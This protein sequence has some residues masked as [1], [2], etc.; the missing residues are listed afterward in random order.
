MLRPQAHVMSLRGVHLVDR[1]SGDGH[2]IRVVDVVTDNWGW[3]NDGFM[4]R[5]FTFSFEAVVR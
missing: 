1:M 4:T 3:F 2:W 5:N